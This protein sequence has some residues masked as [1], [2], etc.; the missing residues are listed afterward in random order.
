MVILGI[1]PGTGR[2]GFAYVESD[3]ADSRS[4]IDCGCIETPKGENRE[5]RLRL[6]FDALNSKMDAR[7]PD[8]MAVE[9]LFFNRNITTAMTVGEARGVI[10]LCA[11]LHSV[12]IAEYTPLQVKEALTGYGR[13]S[14]TEVKE[15]VKI[16][17]GIDK[18]KGPDDVSDAIAIAVC[19]S[20]AAGF[21]GTLC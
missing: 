13:A 12:P 10:L 6:L 8:V 4:M 14:K 17:L 2:T 20:F 21:Q 16:H 5:N 1:D 18:I 15:M 3:G 11:A 7:R 9:Q 19:H